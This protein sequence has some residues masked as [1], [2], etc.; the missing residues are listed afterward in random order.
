MCVSVVRLHLIHL[1]LPWFSLL[2][3]VCVSLWFISLQRIFAVFNFCHKEIVLKQ[4]YYRFYMCVVFDLGASLCDCFLSLSTH[5]I[6]AYSCWCSHSCHLWCIGVCFASLCRCLVFWGRHRHPLVYA[7]PCG[8][9]AYTQTK[10][11]H[12]NI[13]SIQSSSCLH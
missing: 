8:E 9:H 10:N 5:F 6:S 4:I 12:A 3:A 2:T 7:W 11:M 1:S 13:N